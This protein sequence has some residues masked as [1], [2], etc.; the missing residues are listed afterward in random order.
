MREHN[1]ALLEVPVVWTVLLDKWVCFASYI[2]MYFVALEGAVLL[3]INLSVCSS[4]V[5]VCNGQ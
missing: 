3:T 4:A 1:R 5:Q 2:A